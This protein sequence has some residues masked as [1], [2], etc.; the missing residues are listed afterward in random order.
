MFYVSTIIL[1]L[2]PGDVLLVNACGSSIGRIFA[3]LSN[4]LGFRLIAV[5]RNNNYTKELFQLGAS[6]V[7]NTSEESLHNIVKELTNGI[8]VTSAIDSIG[9]VDR[10]ELASCVKPKGILLS[11]GLLSGTPVN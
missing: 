5:V 1:Q 6:Y 9:G 4:I 11:L 8:G 10:T 3:Q 7:I 2:K